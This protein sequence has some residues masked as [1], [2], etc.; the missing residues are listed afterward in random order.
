MRI[1]KQRIQQWEHQRP[2]PAPWSFPH[3]SMKNHWRCLLLQQWTSSDSMVM[4]STTVKFPG[5]HCCLFKSHIHTHRH[6]QKLKTNSSD[7]LIC[8]R[9]VSTHLFTKTE[10]KKYSYS[11]WGTFFSLNELFSIWG[12]QH[13]LAQALFCVKLLF[14]VAKCPVMLY[15]TQA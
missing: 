7:D 3:V 8:L 2:I 15:K 13:M 4:E 11:I 14:Q 1:S 10:N 12:L 9:Y 5:F 6:T